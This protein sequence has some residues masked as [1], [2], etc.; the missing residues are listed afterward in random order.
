MLTNLGKVIQISQDLLV[1][2][3]TVRQPPIYIVGLPRTGTTWIASILNTARGIKYVYE[4]FN[5]QNVPESAPHFMKYLLAHDDAPEFA[6]YCTDAFAGSLNNSF[7][8]IHLSSPYIK[9]RHFPGRVMVKDVHSC[10]ALEWI[11][12]N[13]APITVIVIR[14]PCAVAASWF[15]LQGK[16][17]NSLQ[18]LLIQP[19]LL[20]DYL[21]PFEPVL[22]NAKDFWQKMGA[23][24]GG[25]YYV[26]LQQWRKHPDWILLQHES[27]CLDP[28]GN[29]RKLF[30][31]L[32][33]NWTTKTEQ[34]LDYSTKQ[35]SGQPYQ[36]QRRS[37]REP[38]KWKNE[39]EPEQIE[40]IRQFVKPFGLP[41]Y[42]DF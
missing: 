15:R 27:L 29:Y 5:Y 2:I 6:R 40:K 17:D 39:L 7:T 23:F 10:M 37:S 1:G 19:R 3:K 25:T 14:H 33:L 26:M 8:T 42:S 13:L 41:F 36:P 16:N 28:I 11:N 35:D 38:D 20:N 22:K 24:W 21:K 4:P 32:N 31:Q 34:L 12:H 18:Q 9:F 30:A